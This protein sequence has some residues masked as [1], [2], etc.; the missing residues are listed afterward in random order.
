MSQVCSAQCLTFQGLAAG[1]ALLWSGMCSRYDLC[2]TDCSAR[3]AAVAVGTLRRWIWSLACRP[4]TLQLVASMVETCL[5]A[6]VTLAVLTRMRTMK[7]H[8]CTP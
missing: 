4:N 3:G 1:E 2:R 5:W 8:V 7:I 6:A